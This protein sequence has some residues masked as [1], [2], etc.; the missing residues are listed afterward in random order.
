MKPL[1]RESLAAIAREAIQAHDEWDS[2]HVL[3]TIY[4]TGED[5][6]RC[7]T[8]TVIDTALDPDQYPQVIE[9]RVRE[10]TRKFGPPYALLLQV[11]GFAVVPPGPDA[12]PADRALFNADQIARTFRLRKDKIEVAN[13]WVADVH[14]RAWQALKQRGKEG[15][16]ES[17]YRPG[18]R[19]VGGRMPTALLKAART[20]GSSEVPVTGADGR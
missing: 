10:D 13:A 11:E 5:T 17:F 15:I 4:R 8:L 6:V 18:S 9:A 1:P 14:G 19:D 16:E 7:H 3:A 12:T 20:Y 2:A